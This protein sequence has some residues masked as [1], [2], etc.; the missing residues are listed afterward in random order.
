MYSPGVMSTG[1]NLKTKSRNSTVPNPFSKTKVKNITIHV[2]VIY[3]NNAILKPHEETTIHSLPMP[4]V[5]EANNYN[6]HPCNTLI[7]Y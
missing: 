7:A 5:G 1:C 4:D 3:I 6:A 2:K